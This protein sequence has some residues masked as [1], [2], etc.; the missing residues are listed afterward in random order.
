M[1]PLSREDLVIKLTEC[2]TKIQHLEET[3]KELKENLRNKTKDKIESKRYISNKRLAIY[4]GIASVS[5]NIMVE[6]VKWLFS[7]RA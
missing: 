7:S 4:I 5:V 2:V 1:S 6:V 3:V